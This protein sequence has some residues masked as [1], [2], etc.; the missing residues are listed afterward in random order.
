M[1]S[2][3]W[4]RGDAVTRAAHRR[5]QRGLTLV[6]LT[7]ALGIGALIVGALVNV[8][9]GALA[10]RE[11]VRTREDALEEARYAMQRM[12]RAVQGTT[13][14]LVPRADDPGTAHDESVREP[15]VLA[16]TLDPAID[17]DANGV[18]DADNDGDGRIDEDL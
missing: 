15:G 16:V 17:R 4:S 18:A 2:I 12:V 14:L 11:Q 9:S 6:E 1:R 5:A 10:V 8:A 13:R 3:P 7:L